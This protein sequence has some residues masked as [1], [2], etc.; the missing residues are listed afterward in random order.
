MVNNSL[1]FIKIN[2]IQVLNIIKKNFYLL[3]KNVNKNKFKFLNLNTFINEYLDLETLLMLK[4]F[5]NNYNFK[6]FN[7]S[8]NEIKN[9]DFLNNFTFN[10]NNLNILKN[11]LFININIRLSLPNLNIRFKNLYNKKD[12]NFYYIGFYSNFLFYF[13]N[14]GINILIILYILE[15][16]H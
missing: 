7:D 5:N 13:Q 15:G 8:I 1:K 10:I 14:L 4:L 11:C 3:L 6:L 16:L 12:V 2:W 9:N